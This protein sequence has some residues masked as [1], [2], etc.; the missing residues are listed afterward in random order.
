MKVDDIC[1]SYIETETERSK[2]LQNN[3]MLLI[4][5]D[6]L[7]LS[8]EER[9][10]AEM[11]LAINKF[12]EENKL[13]ELSQMVTL[14]DEK[15]IQY[16]YLKGGALGQLLYQDYFRRICGDIDLWVAP[17]NYETALGILLNLG[18]VCIGDDEHHTKLHKESFFVELHK[19]IFNPSLKIDEKYLQNHT[20]QIEIAK[21]KLTTFS[22]T[23]TF[24]H[25]CYHLYMDATFEYSY[26]KVLSEQTIYLPEL[27]FFRA[28]EIARFIEKFYDKLLWDDIYEDIQKQELSS[29]FKLI[30]M[31]VD[32]LF[33]D[34]FPTTMMNIITSLCYKSIAL[35]PERNK[36]L[37]NYHME[38]NEL[39]Y[40]LSETIDNT[41]NDRNTCVV[42][43]NS[44]SFGIVSNAI[45]ICKC[46]YYRT[47]EGIVF[48]LQVY[49]KDFC[50]TGLDDWNP[51]V[52]DGVNFIIC[53]TAT[54]FYWDIFLFPK[55]VGDNKKIIP[56]DYVHNRH[57]S[58]NY[59]QTTY[60]PYEFGY[61]IEVQLKN[62]II[63]KFALDQKLYLGIVVSDC[64]SATKQREKI[65]TIS[66]DENEWFNPAHFV[67]L[68]NINSTN[69]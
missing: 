65:Y 61:G 63:A 48:E 32:R 43:D 22:I 26:Y 41:W 4:L 51:A 34:F 50:I 64:S 17:S 29:L 5:M 9:K 59:I 56:Y 1:F 23:A 42:F 10:R 46:S 7:D 52:S 14:F 36:F 33:P 30:L 12:M 25:L 37:R 18:Y 28:Y 2:H 6:R 16:I 31:E 35:Y 68:E 57:V 53:G 54:F 67:R 13:K 21:L 58:S 15:N 24:I 40:L 27:F 66:K 19:H 38:T 47:A 20:T 3:R 44:T 45:E 60:K 49:D 55:I 39:R 8:R 69:C 62:E 11:A